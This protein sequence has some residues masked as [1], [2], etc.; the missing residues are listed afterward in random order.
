MPKTLLISSLGSPKHS[1]WNIKAIKNTTQQ[2]LRKPIGHHCD[3]DRVIG[4]KEIY[5][6]FNQVCEAFEYI[7]IQAANT[8]IGQISKTMR[9]KKDTSIT[10]TY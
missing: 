4:N 2:K 9:T 8:I 5:L 6:Q 10:Q 1:T 3:A 7:H